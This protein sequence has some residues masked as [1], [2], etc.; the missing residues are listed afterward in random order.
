MSTAD[1]DLSGDTF[2]LSDEPEVA[3]KSFKAHRRINVWKSFLRH[4]KIAWLSV[5]VVIGI[6]EPILYV[7]SVRPLF[8]SE[9]LLTVAPIMLRNV[10]EDR[11]YQ[12]P[13]YDE[14]VNEQLSLMTR[15]EVLMDALER[16]KEDRAIWVHSDESLR[17]AAARFSQSL[18]AKRLPDSTYISVA[19][20]AGQPQGLASA[21]NAVVDAYM[22]RVKGRSFFGQ[23][24]REETLN[25]RRVELQEEIHKKTEQLAQWARDLGVATFER[26][27]EQNTTENRPTFDAR[28][29]RMEAEA[30]CEAVKKR[31][32]AMRGFDMTGEAQ[33]LLATDAELL[34]VKNVL[35]P[36]KNELKARA[37]GLT[38]AHQ[39]R[40]EIDRLVSEIDSD[41]DRAQKSA[42]ERIKLVLAQR[43]DLKMEQDLQLAQA[44]VEQAREFEKVID[45][46][47]QAQAEKVAKF[48]S[49]YYQAL[50]LRQDTDRLN[51]QLSALEDRIDALRLGNQGPGIVT[52]VSRARIP[53]KPISRPMAALVAFFGFLAVF[54]ALAVPTVVD[55]TDHR[56]MSPVDVEAT[57]DARPIGWV[58]ERT[59]R[60]QRFAEDQV[61]RIALSLERQRR[62][63]QRG[64]IA[65]MSL[66]PAGGTTEIV[67]DL[68]R[69]L[70]AIGSRVVVVEA[71][72]LHPDGRYLAPK[73]FPGLVGALSGQTRLEEVVLP[74][75]DLL[76][77]R[78]PIGNTEGAPLLPNSR[79]LRQVLNHLSSM[80]DMVLVDAPPLFFSS[81]AELIT[82]CAQGVVL[83]VEAGKVVTGELKR[84]VDIVREIGPLM[85]EAVV[86]RVR[87]F[88]GHGYYSDLVK[89]YE[90]AG[91][92][93]SAQGE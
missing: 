75:R 1:E 42:L 43:R 66:R 88:R 93:R 70:R 67:L 69:E 92:P 78:I 32:E 22:A 28:A 68:A 61:R 3:R 71:N 73:G 17:D 74:P 25:E 82:S 30:R 89:Q 45:A 53:E 72:A 49:L 55:A 35:W 4:K 41:L 79:N 84:A 47:N 59:P 85:I 63:H 57:I 91:R 40:K 14:L 77:Y 31:N 54:M 24:V 20:E 2:I 19:L 48:N 13:R 36:R 33:E 58:L 10:I 38:P 62:I 27:L 21:V 15:D 37:M 76:T 18:I 64:Q 52:L 9:S 51:R 46:E 6:A 50:N 44:D 80:Y 26:P 16:L 11:E 90:S 29:R 34:S 86:N 56:V 8:R 65:F 39:G 12:V 83:V 5:L 87:D 7:R 81:D 23:E 60:S